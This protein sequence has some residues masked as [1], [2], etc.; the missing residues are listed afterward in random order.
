M[1][2][3]PTFNI[4]QETQKRGSE[5]GLFDVTRLFFQSAIEAAGPGMLGF[6]PSAA[7]GE[8]REEHPFGGFASQARG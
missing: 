2:E 8:F 3:F 6:D 1:A 5:T 7:V 4:P